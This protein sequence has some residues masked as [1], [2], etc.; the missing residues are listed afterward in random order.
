MSHGAVH[1]YTR[2]LAGKPITAATATDPLV[3]PHPLPPAIEHMLRYSM[4]LAV[5]TNRHAALF[6]LFDPLTPLFPS[7]R[8]LLFHAS[9]IGTNSPPP[10]SGIHVMLTQITNSL[11]KS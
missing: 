10:A 5:S 1:K 2:T 11:Q 7:F 4:L 9:T 6:L 3:T 8:L